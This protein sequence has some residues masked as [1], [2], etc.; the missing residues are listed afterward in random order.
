MKTA[1][2]YAIKSNKILAILVLLITIGVLVFD[3]FHYSSS[4][5]IVEINSVNALIL[6]AQA[7]SY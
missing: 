2:A 3:V 1:I 4:Y 7:I 5:G 6:V